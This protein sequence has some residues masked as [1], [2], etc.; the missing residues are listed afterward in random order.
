LIQEAFHVG[1]KIDHALLGLTLACIAGSKLT[2]SFT[3]IMLKG[4]N[5]CQAMGKRVSHV[6]G[7]SI[8]ASTNIFLNAEV[9]MMMMD[10]GLLY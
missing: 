8:T 5:G 6:S 7:S 2:L 9:V 4:F 3:L 1:F 10:F